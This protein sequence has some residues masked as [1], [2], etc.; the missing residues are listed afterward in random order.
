M[1][2]R[3]FFHVYLE[4]LFIST[5]IQRSYSDETLL[6]QVL[7]H[8]VEYNLNEKSKKSQDNIQRFQKQSSNIQ[9]IQRI[10]FE[11]KELTQE[12]EFFSYL[13][14]AQKYLKERNLS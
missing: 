3:N 7:E 4:T 1:L 9:K 10:D 12:Q 5:I 14:E 2:L 11:T 8:T 13:E 6:Q